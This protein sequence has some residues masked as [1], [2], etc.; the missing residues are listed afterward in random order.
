VTKKKK[1][2]GNKYKKKNFT[3][4]M[5]LVYQQLDQSRKKRTFNCALW[6]CLL[7]LGALIL[8]AFFCW[9]RKPELEVTNPHSPSL[10][11]SPPL[12]LNTQ[13]YIA[14]FQ[15]LVDVNELSS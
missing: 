1:S 6:T 12:A 7:V 9:P 2:S 14:T 4:F 5:T 11:L 10:T 3:Y 8:T 13:N 15:F